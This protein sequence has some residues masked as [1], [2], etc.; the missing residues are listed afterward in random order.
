MY[1]FRSWLPVAFLAASKDP[2]VG[3]KDSAIDGGSRY[4]GKQFMTRPPIRPAGAD[5]GFFSKIKY[6]AGKFD[7]STG[8]LKTQPLENRRNGFGT[9]MPKCRDQF[10]SHIETERYRELLKVRAR[11]VLC[12]QGMCFILC[13]CAPEG[14]CHGG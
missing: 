8:Y 2:Y 4:R 3:N 10:T 12:T 9:H 11:L 5:T 7:D 13:C 6:D 14:K 1:S